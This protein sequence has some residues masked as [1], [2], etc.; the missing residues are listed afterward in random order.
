[1]TVGDRVELLD[2]SRRQGVVT[3]VIQERGC[4]CATVFVRLEPRGE[5]AG[6]ATEVRRR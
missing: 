1:M 3:G 5:W 6:R 4:G 2:G